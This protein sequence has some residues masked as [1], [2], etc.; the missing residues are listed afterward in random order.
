MGYDRAFLLAKKARVTYG[1]TSFSGFP[2]SFPIFQSYLSS[3]GTVQ[4]SGSMILPLLAPG[5]QDIQEGLLFQFLPKSARYRR[6]TVIT[7]I[8]T[9]ILAM[10]LASFASTA[11]QIV[12]SQGI[13]F[14]LGGIL[15]N[16]VHVSVFPEW[17]D[18]KRGQAMGLIWLG[19]RSGGLAFPLVCQWLLDKHGYSKTLRVLIAPMLALLLP[20]IILLRGRYPASTVQSK[21]IEQPKSKLAALRT[22]TLPFYLL[23]AILFAAVTNVPMM[24]ITRFAA[25]LT[26][27]SA[28]RALA[29]SLVFLGN[30]L[31]PY[32]L[33]RL[34]DNAFHPSLMGASAI[35]TSLMH[36]LVWGFVK[37]RSG[38]FGY[39]ICVGIMSGGKLQ[40][41]RV[42]IITKHIAKGFVTAY[43]R[44]SRKSQLETTS[45]LLLC[46][47]FLASLMGLLSCQWDQSALH[48]LSYHQRSLLAHMQSESTRYDW[49]ISHLLPLSGGL[50]LQQPLVAY[51]GGMTMASGLL[52]LTPCCIR[53]VKIIWGRLSVRGASA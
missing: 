36:L 28:D 31:G 14:G 21:P 52:A 33:G 42:S 40:P 10:V 25:D 48:C 44:S 3:Q 23:I 19:F 34:S 30:M 5:L 47:V 4:L 2:Q 8:I 15:L 7:G 1:L 24:F 20:S 27:S 53:Y 45:F 22:P 11:L 39:A 13:L 12:A 37:G 9:I 50:M 43:S 17:F 32:L 46:I 18:Q 41:L 16:F 26:L 35:S 38:L 49:R 51:A 29:L 6:A